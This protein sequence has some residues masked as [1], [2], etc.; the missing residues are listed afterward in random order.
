MRITIN[1][2]ELKDPPSVFHSLFNEKEKNSE[3]D[4]LK[5]NSLEIQFS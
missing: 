3:I 5:R 2:R 1:Y 4:K